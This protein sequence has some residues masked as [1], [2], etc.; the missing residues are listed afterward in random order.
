MSQF[1]S[2]NSLRADELF[3]AVTQVMRAEEAGLPFPFSGKRTPSE[4]EVTLAKAKAEAM[5]RAKAKAA[6]K[7]KAAAKAKA[8]ASD[9]RGTPEFGREE[10]KRASS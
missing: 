7:D 4:R 3:G 10:A 2:V 1:R 9:G 8:E 5:A 6:A